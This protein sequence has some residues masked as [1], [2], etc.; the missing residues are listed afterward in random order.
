MLHLFELA[1]VL[2]GNNQRSHGGWL[3]NDI[4]LI[5]SLVLGWDA[6]FDEFETI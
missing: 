3:D 5:V 4:A 6:S 1:R 2:S